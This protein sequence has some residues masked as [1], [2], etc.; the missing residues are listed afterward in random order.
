NGVVVADTNGKNSYTVY[1]YINETP[2]LKCGGK[3]IVDWSS[4][5]NGNHNYVSAVNSTGTRYG[6]GNNNLD[7]AYGV[8][9]V[10]FIGNPQ[11][12]YTDVYT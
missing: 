1:N 9:E 11:S 2:Q 10:F 5:S 6:G 4:C 3:V 7:I 8:T 12:T